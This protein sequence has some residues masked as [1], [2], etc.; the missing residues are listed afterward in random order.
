MI[1]NKPVA[2]WAK[3]LA[4]LQNPPADAPSIWFQAR[5]RQLEQI[6][7]A[8]LESEGLAPRTNVRP[9]GE[10]IDG[11][12]VMGDRTYLLEAKW[13]K[14][15]TPASELYAFR[16][17]VDGKLA[18]TLGVFITMNRYSD[19]AIDA[20]LAGKTVNLILFS[21]DDMMQIAQGRWNFTE[22]LRAKLRI[23]AEIGSP[24]WPLEPTAEAR[25]GA[26]DG[27]P[28]AA[29]TPAETWTLI[30]ESK[31][32]ERALD[33]LLSRFE[34]PARSMA[35]KF[36]VAE[37][38]QNMASIV[39]R[40]AEEAGPSHTAVFVDADVD[41]ET[42]QALG[43]HAGSVVIFQPSFA[44]WLMEA[45]DADTYNHY[46]FLASSPDKEVRRM[47]SVANLDQLLTASPDFA[48]LI[49]RMGLVPRSS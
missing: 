8:M 23:A 41:A 45:T 4:E 48:R 47:A 49:D 13:R 32:D 29:P 34:S 37:G 11:S 35:L 21:A 26:A 16:G 40:L 25:T 36:W 10:E 6:L 44:D 20:L 5:G 46:V 38:G 22:A 39:Q 1:E 24:Y 42:R 18:G 27:A 30:V 2:V 28:P 12:F 17:K 15:P 33:R 19:D 3:R 14:G 7:A 43:E 31:N 9:D